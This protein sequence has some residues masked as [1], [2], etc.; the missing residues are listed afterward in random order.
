[1]GKWESVGV[2]CWDVEVEVE[3]EVQGGMLFESASEKQN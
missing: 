1:M 3:K 2:F